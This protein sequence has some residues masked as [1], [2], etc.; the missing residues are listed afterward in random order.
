[1]EE[2]EQV[3]RGISKEIIGPKEKLAVKEKKSSKKSTKFLASETMKME[4]S[5]KSAGNLENK[6]SLRMARG[7][8]WTCDL[9]RCKWSYPMAIL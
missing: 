1:M 7:Q 5:L 2:T 9:S 6:E 8:L 4:T 3:S